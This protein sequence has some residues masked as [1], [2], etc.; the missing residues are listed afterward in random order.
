MKKK[1]VLSRFRLYPGV[2]TI[3]KAGRPE[4]VRQNAAT[5]DIDLTP[6]DLAEID[7]AFPPPSAHAPL[8]TL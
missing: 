6:E 3:P 5:I 7:A 2:V 8:E 1:K 4:H